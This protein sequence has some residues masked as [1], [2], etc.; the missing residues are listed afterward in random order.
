MV[1]L[2]TLQTMNMT[3]MLVLEPHHMLLIS[4]A[5]VL[6]SISEAKQQATEELADPSE[7]SVTATCF[8]LFASACACCNMMQDF[9]R[10]L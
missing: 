10:M 7:L 5:S 8:Q 3:C 6:G 1:G 4:A 9:A 2:A